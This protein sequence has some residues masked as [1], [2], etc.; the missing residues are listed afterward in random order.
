MEKQIFNP[1]ACSL[2]IGVEIIDKALSGIEQFFHG[3]NLPVPEIHY[4]YIKVTGP[5][6]SVPTKV[7]RF[8]YNDTTGEILVG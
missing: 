7:A 4:D 2:E 8:K 6:V 1:N 5:W 3:V